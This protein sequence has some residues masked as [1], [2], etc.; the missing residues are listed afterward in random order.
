MKH[1]L[2]SV[3]V[4]NHNGTVHLPECLETLR[5]QTYPQIEIIVIDNGST[6][7][8]WEICAQYEGVTFLE[9]GYNWGFGRGNNEGSK[10]AQG[11]FLFFVNNDMRFKPDV[12]SILVHKI[13]QDDS[14]FAL[15]IKHYDWDGASVNHA[16]LRFKRGGW[17]SLLCPFVDWFEVDVQDMVP[18]PWANGASLFCRADRFHELG[19]FDST[20]FIDYEDAD[21]CWRAWLRGWK[22]Y[23][24][25]EAQC[26]HKKGATFSAGGRLSSARSNHWTL[27]KRRRYYSGQ[28]NRVRFAMK[29][30]S[31][32]VNLLVFLRNHLFAMAFLL[33]GR[34]VNASVMVCS[35]WANVAELP[36]I[37][38]QRRRILTQSRLSSEDLIQAF[39]WKS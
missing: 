2:V 27:W 34:R 23:Y 15:D 13:Q 6:D 16:A 33:L 26:Y 17:R 31:G 4:L 11:E 12:I 28:K 30:M 7:S 24:V 3:L 10:Q 39:W 21:L 37:L 32:K 1:G 36:E 29:T 5:A 35:W 38:A 9:L 22:T 8:S 14:I 18:V 25:P 19:G 20:F